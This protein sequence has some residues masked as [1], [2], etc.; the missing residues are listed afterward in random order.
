MKHILGVQILFFQILPLVGLLLELCGKHQVPFFY[1]PAC[2]R[3]A[4]K[5]LASPHIG[6]TCAHFLRPG[7][8]PL[9]LREGSGS[10]QLIGVTLICKHVRC[11]VLIDTGNEF[12]FTGT[13]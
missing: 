13:F 6:R 10:R 9:Q 3:K 8:A 11:L 1:E 12:N 4:A 2:P 7:S 5:P